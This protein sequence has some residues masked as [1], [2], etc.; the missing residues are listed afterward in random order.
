MPRPCFSAS[1][2]SS[3]QAA[4]Q[5]KMSIGSRPTVLSVTRRRGGVGI[6]VQGLGI[7]VDEDRLR[8]LVEQAVGR[9]DEGEGAGDDLVALAP[10]ELA[11]AEVERRGAARHRDR[12]LD[13]EEVGEGAL[14]ALPHRPEREPPR[15]QDLEHQL[16]LALAEVR[17][18]QRDRLEV[19]HR[20][21]AHWNAYSSESTSACQEAS[22]T[23]PDTPIVPH[24]R[25]P[26]AES[27]STRVTASVPRS[28]SR[29]R[30]L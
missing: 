23:F 18:R 10:A 29:I 21:L 22:I 1:A 28:W 4:G 25:S 24:S 8:A 27:S 11:H 16:L 6:D 14:E 5:P 2:S 30:T 15:A 19:A 7:D 26:S 12:V 13:P 3:G 20:R 9:G 17:A